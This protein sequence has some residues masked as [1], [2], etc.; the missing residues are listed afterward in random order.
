MFA[1]CFPFSRI[2]AKASFIYVQQQTTIML[3]TVV[4]N[5]VCSGLVGM[6]Y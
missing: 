1:V 5:M 6:H 2:G 3:R 4:T